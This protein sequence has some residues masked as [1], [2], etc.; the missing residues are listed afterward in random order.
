M[1]PHWRPRH[2]S[3]SESP[4]NRPVLLDSRWVPR[5]SV[6]SR[7][8]PRTRSGPAGTGAA[9]RSSPSSISASLRASRPPSHYPK[10]GTSR[11]STRPSTSPGAL[12][13]RIAA[14]FG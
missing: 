9:S 3:A 8:C 12:I 5:A 2:G 4:L 11:F 10:Q 13:R 6:A 7:T 14:R 1:Q